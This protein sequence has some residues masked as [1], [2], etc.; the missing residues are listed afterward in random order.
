[1]SGLDCS[2]LVQI[3]TKAAGEDPPG[4][5]T[6]Q[7][8]YNHFVLLGRSNVWGPGSLVFYGKDAGNISH[9]A[10]ALNNYQMI[11]AGGGDSTCVNIDASKKK[12]AFVKIS[13]IKGRSDFISIIRPHYSKIGLI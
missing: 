6:A 10:F 3:L 8:L 11:E 13:L 2:G 1:M 5:Q 7:G 12:D 4:D 9:V